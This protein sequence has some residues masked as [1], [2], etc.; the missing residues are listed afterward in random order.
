MQSKF[1]R[2]QISILSQPHPLAPSHLQIRFAT[3]SDCL[4]FSA[5]W[6]EAS[7]LHPID[8]IFFH[9]PN[10]RSFMLCFHGR[11]SSLFWPIHFPIHW[12]LNYRKK[13]I[14]MSFHFV[15]FFI[16]FKT[17]FEIEFFHKVFFSVNSFFWERRTK[18]PTNGI[19]SNPGTESLFPVW[20]RVFVGKALHGQL[21]WLSKK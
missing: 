19:L 17:R 14:L 12:L 10:P 7:P 18:L 15:F 5:I 16:F 11:N 9:L 6:Q 4:P 13:S 3:P 8:H 20:P 2:E 21:S 1:G